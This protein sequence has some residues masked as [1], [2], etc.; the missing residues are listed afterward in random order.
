MDK[1]YRYT[2][3]YYHE[4]V[5]AAAGKELEDSAPRPTAR[6]LLFSAL[7]NTRIKSVMGYATYTTEDILKLAKG[8]DYASH[9]KGFPELGKDMAFPESCEPHL[10]RDVNLI[11]CANRKDAEVIGEVKIVVS[12]INDTKRLWAYIEGGKYPLKVVSVEEAIKEIEDILSKV[13]KEIYRP[14]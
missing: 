2:V 13:T 10:S 5:Y 8:S 11:K 6:L 4:S 9:F 3:F 14:V 1:K 12:S 7:L